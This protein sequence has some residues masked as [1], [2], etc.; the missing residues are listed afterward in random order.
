MVVN[1]LD[2][3]LPVELV[4]KIYKQVHQSYMRDICDTIT[5]KI[6]FVLIDKEQET[7]TKRNK[8]KKNNCNKLSFLICENQNY[9][10]CLL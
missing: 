2:R 3:F 7:N 5:F 4:D 10:R 1:Y 8:N 9:Y 6:V